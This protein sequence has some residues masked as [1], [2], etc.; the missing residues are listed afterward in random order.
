MSALTATTATD[1]VHVSAALAA[2][3]RRLAVAGYQPGTPTA[4]PAAVARVDEFCAAEWPCPT[5][6]RPGR[7]LHTFT[8]PT[9]PTA[10]RSIAFCPACGTGED[11]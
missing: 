10:W 9:N 7:R 8:H 6:R 1:V 11:L 5:C 3:V 2:L 4:R